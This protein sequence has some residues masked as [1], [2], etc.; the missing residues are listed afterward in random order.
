MKLSEHNENFLFGY[1]QGDIGEEQLEA[2]LVTVEWAEEVPA[3]ERDALA[4]LR[5]IVSEYGEGVRERDEVKR[6]AAA[7]LAASCG[8]AISYTWDSNVTTR[9]LVEVFA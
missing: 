6:K 7:L 9:V 3:A 4:G 5:L 1:L 2:W 8:E